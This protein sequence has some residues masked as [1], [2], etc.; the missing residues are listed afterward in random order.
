MFS[1]DRFLFCVRENAA[2]VHEYESGHDGSDGKCDCIGLIIGAVKLAGG[3]WPGAHGSNWAARNAMATLEHITDAREM[4]LGEIVYKAKEPGES[5]YAL[6]SRYENSGDL[7]DYYHVGVVTGV[8]PLEITH[9]TNVP[10]GIQRDSKIG[11]W[12]WGGKLKYV[13]YDEGGGQ[14]EPIYQAKVHAEGNDY[15]VKMRAQARKNVK[16]LAKIPQGTIVNVLGIVGSDEGDW[17]FIL[18]NGQTGYMMNQYLIPVNDGD[19]D[20]EQDM[21]MVPRETLETW[22]DVLEEM[23]RD[24]RE[25]LGKG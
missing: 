7:R 1:L 21:V 24:M 8:D 3:T 10:G 25:R 11:N 2:R 16:I 14:M 15:P 9:C 18:Y 22:A 13:N 4:F 23:A 19:E 12:R 6:P 17:G 20:E 5:G